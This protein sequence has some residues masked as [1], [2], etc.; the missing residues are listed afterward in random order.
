MQDQKKAVNPLDSLTPE[1]IA[2]FLASLSGEKAKTAESALNKKRKA[3]IEKKRQ[4]R[5]KE[6]KESEKIAAEFE[7]N[8]DKIRSIIK[9]TGIKDCR[10]TIDIDKDGTLMAK[11]GVIRKGP[12][13][14]RTR[15]SDLTAEIYKAIQDKLKAGTKP[16]IKDDGKVNIG[17][18]VVTK[19]QAV[20]FATLM[21]KLNGTEN[22]G[23]KSVEDIFGVN[24]F[25]SATIGSEQQKF[26]VGN[27]GSKMGI[28]IKELN[29]K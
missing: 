15:S 7:K 3:E 25:G 16:V 28:L 21:A 8:L 4:A 19:R 18:L 24:F 9:K 12:A 26:K 27:G 22:P 1:Q 11:T 29:R 23:K 14:T 6:K 20:C 10:I 5:E 13:G 17:D 2:S